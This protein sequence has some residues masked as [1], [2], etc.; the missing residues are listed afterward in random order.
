MCP[1]E[2]LVDDEDFSLSSNLV[3][4]NLAT[5]RG[6][7]P[8]VFVDSKIDFEVLREILGGATEDSEEGFGLNWPGKRE[9]RRIALSQSGG[10]LLPQPGLSLNWDET[11]NSV[12][13][14]DNLEALKLL[15]KGYSGKVKFIFID[16]PYNTG[17][18]FVYDDNFS[19]GIGSYLKFSDQVSAEG[20]KLQANTDSTGRRHS[21]W[22]SMIYPRLLLA[23]NLLREDGAIAVSIDDDEG[24]HL[25]NLMDEVF[26]RE[27]YY[28]TIVWEKKY[29]P[30]N[31]AKRFSDVHDYVHVYAKSELF[32]RNLFPRTE[33]N[34][35]PYKYDDNNGR[36]RYRTD[37]LSVRTYSASND[38]PVANPITGSEHRPPAGA[39][40]RFSKIK[41]NELVVDNK[42]YWG[43][44]GTGAPQLKR[45]LA[46][47]QQGTVP[48]TLWKHG[49]A[50]HTDEARKE[51]KALFGTSSVFDT[52]KPTRLIKRLLQVATNP[53]G[54]QIVM[55]FFAGSGTTG[56]A[57]MSQNAEDGGDRRYIL[58]QLNEPGP[59][60]NY[61]SLADVTRERLRRAGAAVTAEA[62]L[63]ADRL[64][65]GFRS[66]KLGTSNLR[67]WQASAADIG[68]Q[69]EL[70]IDN[71]FEDRSELDILFEVM[72][73]L[74]LELN[75]AVKTFEVD[76]ATLQSLGYG[77]LYA[78]LSTNV[79]RQ[80]GIALAEKIISLREASGTEGEVTVVFRDSGFTD[81]SAKLNVAEMLFQAGI[82]ALRTI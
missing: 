22:L 7:L 56:H 60:E 79:T 11:E 54:K 62:G 15:Q 5:I 47:V 51:I 24:A 80:V 6:L 58:V 12:I 64:D 37:N 31:D 26:G 16:P 69:L 71:V 49:F 32:V 78:C 44:D 41:F 72:L 42:I 36:G 43:K 59:D 13:E 61:E 34:D 27:N 23:R 50:G 81:D 38:F 17:N 29:A 19:D 74:G 65:I 67:P 18:D 40:W 30:A 70:S 1:V 75:T 82:P 63:T 68:D 48:T 39:C 77:S 2:H 76:G 53:D 20:I 46:E 25:R 45:Y 52:P 55:D 73:K 4:R 21:N 8:E 57:V 10:T 66:F 9:S 35:L 33:E 28:G 3:R 14:A